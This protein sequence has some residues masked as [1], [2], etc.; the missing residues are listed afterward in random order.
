MGVWQ[1]EYKGVPGRGKR[2]CQGLA[3]WNS[4]MLETFFVFHVLNNVFL[5]R[6]ISSKRSASKLPQ[7]ENQLAVH[8]PIPMMEWVGVP[9]GGGGC[10]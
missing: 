5:F 2:I 4:M 9:Q 6:M 3:V 10:K 8:D 7:Q 1:V